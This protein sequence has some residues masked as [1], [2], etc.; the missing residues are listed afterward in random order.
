[1]RPRRGIVPAKTRPEIVSKLSADTVKA[2]ADPTAR[3][4]LERAGY[5]VVGS[6]PDDRQTLLRS[7][8]DKWSAVI[9]TVGIKIN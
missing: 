6:S 8:I 3:N 5:T 4:K 9:K 7:E 1:M 2:L